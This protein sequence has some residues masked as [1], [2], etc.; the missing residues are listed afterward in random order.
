M[1]VRRLSDLSTRE[2]RWTIVRTV[3]GIVGA[4]VLLIGAFYA[5]PVGNSG[6]ADIVWRVI[7]T[8]ALLAVLIT[9]QSLRIT[10]R[11]LPELRAIVAL[12]VLFP[13]FFVLF[14]SIYLSMDHSAG[15][16][17]SQPLDHTRALDFTITVFSTVGFGDITPTTDTARLVVSTQMIL[18]LVLIGGAVRILFGAAKTRLA[19]NGGAEE[20]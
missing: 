3:A 13:L 2:R 19:H 7:L 11:D 20:H 18:D 10:R 5:L 12:G 6:G 14:S 16:M 1:S 15:T 4:W 8:V 17:F 9:W